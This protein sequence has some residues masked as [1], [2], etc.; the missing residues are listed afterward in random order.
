MGPKNEHPR[1][2]CEQCKRGASSDAGKEVHK[3]VNRK[4]RRV[5]KALLKRD[6][7]DF[8]RLIVSTPYTD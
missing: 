1:C 7:V 6:G 5:T 2:G 8:V 4:I 3:Q